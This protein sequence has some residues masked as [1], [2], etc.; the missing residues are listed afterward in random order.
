MSP[1]LSLILNI[2]VVLD[3]YQIKANFSRLYNVS[4]IRH[5]NPFLIII[6]IIIPE[7]VLYVIIQ[8]Y[9]YNLKLKLFHRLPN[10]S[11]AK[12]TN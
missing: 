10:F 1:L 3:Y 5:L 9:H 7:H 2:I 4:K 6:R 11:N 12:F 8:N